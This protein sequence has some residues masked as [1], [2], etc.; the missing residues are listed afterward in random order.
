MGLLTTIETNLEGDSNIGGFL[1]LMDRA[2]EDLATGPDLVN[3]VQDI[4]K[5]ALNVSKICG[6]EDEEEILLGRVKQFQF[7]FPRLLFF[8]LFVSLFIH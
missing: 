2:L 4:V 6:R 8:F 1:D 7:P 5:H 3:I